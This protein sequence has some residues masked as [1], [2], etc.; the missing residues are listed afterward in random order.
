MY[1]V[2]KLDTLYI[3]Y[4]LCICKVTTYGLIVVVAFVYVYIYII[5]FVKELIILLLQFFGFDFQYIN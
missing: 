5:S 3:H 1:K 4:K 2:V